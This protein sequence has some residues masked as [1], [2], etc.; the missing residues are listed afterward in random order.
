MNHGIYT[1]TSGALAT[2]KRF[3][4]VANNLANVNTIGFKKQTIAFASM[5]PLDKTESEVKKNYPEE[6]RKGV[7]N[8]FPF[9]DITKTDFSEGYIKETGNKLDFAISGKGFF[10][11]KDGN[12]NIKFT[13]NGNFKINK[14]GFLV[15]S[16]GEQVLDEK[17]NSIKL[18]IGTAKYIY[19]DEKGNIFVDNNLIGKMAIM[20]FDDYSVLQ[21]A[22]YTDFIINPKIKPRPM[23]RPSKDYE[24]QQ[25]YLEGSNV[26]VVR[27]MVTLIEVQRHYQAD[28]KVI[29]TIDNQLDA[30]AVND[31]G[32]VT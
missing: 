10:M 4:I 17:Y 18:N 2:E 20:D 9:T 19:V 1:I 12:G 8:T 15:N 21:R 28:Q 11:V 29:T 24:L 26:N 3:Q 7:F 6:I 22:G 30:K 14:D 31:V 16:N 27:Q 32:R 13:R 23:P 25:G 5:L